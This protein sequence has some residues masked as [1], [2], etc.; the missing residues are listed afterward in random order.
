MEEKT[1]TRDRILKAAMERFIHYGYP[2]TT[3]AEIAA[4]C[5]MSAGNIYRF[6]PSKLDIAEAMARKFEGEM[7]QDLS[8]IARQTNVSARR[9]VSMFF[10]H[11]MRRTYEM[12]DEKP[13]VVELAEVLSSER[14]AHANVNLASQRVHLVQILDDGVSSGEFAPG[15]N[16]FRAE[17]IQSA[18]MKFTYPQ[19][20][21]HLTLQKLE[22]EFA[23]V[24]ALILDGLNAREPAS[25]TV[26]LGDV[27]SA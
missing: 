7:L 19:L 12:L 18:L 13:K 4:D 15:D 25:D 23:G 26:I 10:E 14:P 22:R 9:R 24:T 3:I 1:D 16:L 8:Q 20:F 5:G 11:I 27:K 21:S 2:K 17:M 6:F